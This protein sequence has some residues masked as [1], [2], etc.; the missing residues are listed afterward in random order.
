MGDLVRRLRLRALYHRHFSGKRQ[1]RQFLSSLSFFVTFAV[2]RTITHAI[3]RN[4]GPFHNVSRGGLHIHHLV[5]GIFGLLA[6]GYLWL[7]QIGGGAED[8]SPAASRLTALL[9]GAASALTLDEFA[10]WLRLEDDY[11][12]REG[13]ASIDAVVLFA[14]LLSVGLWGRWFFRDVAR[15]LLRAADAVSRHGYRRA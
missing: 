14:S 8:A 1:E 10:L 3:R 12:N 13:R 4:V 6:V 2:T 11:W 7:D 15:E 9:Y 5:W